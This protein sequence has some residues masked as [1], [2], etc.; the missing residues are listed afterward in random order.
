[1]GEGMGNRAD[2]NHS[3]ATWRR[4]SLREGYT[5]SACAM[6]AATAATRVLLTGK[7]LGSITVDLPAKE[8]VTFQ[9]ER[10][11]IG[12]ESVTCGI[13]KDAGD[14]P[15][16]THGLE[17]QATVSWSDQ[18]GITLKGGDGVGTVTRPGL[19]VPVGEPAINP[20]PRRMITGAVADE[21]GQ[22]AAGRGLLVTIS[23]LG[24]EDIAKQT[25]NPKLGIVGGISILGTSGIV[26]PFSTSAY[27]ASIYVELKMA[28][29]NGVKHAVL[30]TG[31]RSAAYAQIHYPNLPEYAFVQV[32]DHIDYGLKQVRRLGFEQVTL[33]S[34]IGKVSKLAQGRMQ[35]HVS[36]GEVD[37]GFLAEVAA[38]LGADDV[39]CKR[40]LEANTAHHVQVMLRQAGLE[41]LEARLVEMA[42]G[43]AAAFIGGAAG[44]EVLLWRVR[45]DLLAE[46]RAS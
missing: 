34:M 27:R 36:E 40:I 33:S 14:D 3:G 6:A 19:P 31:K 8:R 22:A 5:T 21:V 46:G 18:P 45:G 9:L 35:T 4:D 11:E 28:A 38:A 44:V 10:C 16:V 29:H 23:V 32:G 24:G 30:T 17:I 25:M 39:L 13:I 26:K 37:L 20:V 2:G 7:K 15:D 41:G 12:T 43:A 42:A 1:V